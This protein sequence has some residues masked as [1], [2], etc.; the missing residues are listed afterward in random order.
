MV[1]LRVLLYINM[2]E[3]LIQTDLH[4]NSC[5]I[6]RAITFHVVWVLNFF[7]AEKVASWVHVFPYS[8][9]PAFTYLATLL[10]C[11]GECHSV[12]SADPALIL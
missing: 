7:C 5:V 8:R 10:I 2:P 11:L 6:P 12:L 1:I 3:D 9:S 4:F